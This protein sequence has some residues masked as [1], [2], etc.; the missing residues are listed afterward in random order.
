MEDFC[1]SREFRWLTL[2]VERLAKMESQEVALMGL[3]LLK[4]L[5]ES[6]YC[7]QHK[8]IAIKQALPEFIALGGRL[9]DRLKQLQEALDAS[10]QPSR[11]ASELEKTSKA[12]I[13]Q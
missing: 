4:L 6:D 2:L 11:P 3:W 10:Q 5:T 7:Y 9:T 1:D 12:F 13:T 8:Y